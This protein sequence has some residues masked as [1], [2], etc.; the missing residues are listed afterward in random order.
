[1]RHTSLGK[2]TRPL[3]GIATLLPTRRNSSPKLMSQPAQTMSDDAEFQARLAAAQNAVEARLIAHLADT[4]TPPR[5]TA[6][7]N[8]AV[9]GGG[10]RFRPFLVIESARLFGAA[11][12]AALDVAA[13]LECIH[14]YSL[15]HDDLPAMDNDELRRGRPTV[16]KAYDEWT[17]ILAGDALLTLA[18]EILADKVAAPPE[19]RVRL[20]AELAKASGPAGMVGGQMLDL[21]ADKLGHHAGSTADHVRRLQSMKTGA[22]IRYGCIA[23]PILAG[24]SADVAALARFG[25]DVGYAFQISDDLLDATGDVAVVGKAVGKDTAAG[26]ATLVSLM[27]VDA[28]RRALAVVE[29][30]AIAALAPYGPAAATLCAAARLMARRDR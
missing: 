12:D 7:M 14:C 3:C 27:G 26:K 28:A 2:R 20:A 10:K 13:A 30:D 4:K 18:F 29:A 19:V 8:H 6:A 25:D 16:W 11:A 23:G 22:L 21:E 1:M 24:R 5:L 15:V 17:A 9:L